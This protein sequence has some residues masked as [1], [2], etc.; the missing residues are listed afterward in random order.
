MPTTG[1]GEGRYTSSGSIQ[2]TVIRWRLFI[3]PRMTVANEIFLFIRCLAV[4]A[5]T[6]TRS[7]NS[8]SFVYAQ[9]HKLR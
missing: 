5:K 8:G 1:K 2:I 3:Y 7:I 6:I 4:D 9:D